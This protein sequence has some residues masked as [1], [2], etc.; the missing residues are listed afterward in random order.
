MLGERGEASTS[1]S[2]ILR[3]LP[4]PP[5][6]PPSATPPPTTTSP[7]IIQSNEPKEKVLLT[8]QN[9]VEF[10][11]EKDQLVCEIDVT[12]GEVCDTDRKTKTSLF[13]RQLNDILDSTSAQRKRQK[14]EKTSTSKG[15]R[16][17]KLFGIKTDKT[18]V[19]DNNADSVDITL[20]IRSEPSSP[21]TLRRFFRRSS[22]QKSTAKMSKS[23]SE[24][25][26]NASGLSSGQDRDKNPKIVDELSLSIKKKLKRSKSLNDGQS[27]TPKVEL[28]KPK[29]TN[30]FEDSDDEIVTSE[31]KQ[32][33]PQP[34]QKQQ[35]PYPLQQQQQQQQQ[36][37]IY[38]TVVCERLS[39]NKNEAEIERL[40]GGIVEK[41]GCQMCSNSGNRCPECKMK[42]KRGHRVV[43][44]YDN[45]DIDIKNNNNRLNPIRK[46]TVS[47]LI[48]ECEDYVKT[49][50]FTRDLSSEILTMFLHERSNHVNSSNPFE[51]DSDAFTT[52]PATPTHLYDT[53]SNTEAQAQENP[54]SQVSHRP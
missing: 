10:S 27:T 47:E 8:E 21:S 35:Q 5:K 20:K 7:P 25:S 2:H 34:Q 9:N 49:E 48:A 42:Q 13:E 30:P 4:P 14:V 46:V 15:S 44:I 52:P 17:R 18:N 41:R 11:L 22:F 24:T 26:L 31:R 51:T 3:Q 37:P 6:G 19:D 23:R 33:E 45:L 28:L 32:K 40:F 16:L 38:Q 43:S 36:Q 12:D 39:S 54:Y 1:L 53:A 29:S 50:Q